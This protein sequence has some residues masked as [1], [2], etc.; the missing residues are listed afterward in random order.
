MKLWEGLGYYNR[1]RN[2]QKAAS[3][4]VVELITEHCLHL[5]RSC[6]SL[7]GHWKLHSRRYR[8]LLPMDI[9]VPAVDGNVLRVITRIHGGSSGYHETVC[10]ANR[11]KQKLQDDYAGRRTWRF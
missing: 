3:V 5:M 10:Y 8:I 4:S 11:S 9:P 7:E 2:M 6:S 1:V